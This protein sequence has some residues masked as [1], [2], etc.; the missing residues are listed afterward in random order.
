MPRK[1]AARAIAP[2]LPV[3]PEKDSLSVASDPELVREF[4]QDESL[5][6]DQR[7]SDLFSGSGSED[8]VTVSLHRREPKIFQGRNASGFCEDLPPVLDQSYQ[9]YIKDKYGGEVYQATLKINGRFRQNVC[10]RIP[11]LAPRFPTADSSG[12]VSAKDGGPSLPANESVE[13]VSIGGS[14][15]EFEARLARYVMIQRTLNPP[16]ASEINSVLLQYIL[17]SKQGRPLLEQVTDI[18]GVLTALKEL[19]PAPSGDGD[20]GIMGLIGKALD[21]LPQ[22]IAQHRAEALADRP[23][24]LAGGLPGVSAVPQLENNVNPPEKRVIAMPPQATLKEKM[25]YAAQVLLDGFVCET[26]PETIVRRFDLELE[27]TDQQRAVIGSFRDVIHS[28]VM[29]LFRAYVEQNVDDPSES[30]VTDM[31]VYFEK[32]FGVFVKL[33]RVSVKLE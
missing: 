21:T 8:R 15:R 19:I 9:Q 26:E 4:D 30:L 23:P 33:D 27:L 5:D 3:D 16:P 13:G 31:N 18:A 32:V 29:S 11:G 6:V 12:P 17:E 14:E 20:G 25:M 22:L 7:I 2:T 28:Q 24:E 1:P 10:I